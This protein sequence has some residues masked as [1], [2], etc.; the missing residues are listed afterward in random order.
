MSWGAQ[1]RSKDA[2][3]PSVAGGRSRKPKLALCGIQPH[4]K[5]VRKKIGGLLLAPSSPPPARTPAHTR[6]PSRRRERWWHLALPILPMCSPALP[7]PRSGLSSLP[8]SEP[9]DTLL[10][11][12]L[13]FTQTDNRSPSKL[14]TGLLLPS[15]D[16]PGR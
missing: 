6:A 10:S 12:P 5:V 8:N 14:Q 3:T 7:A 16:A 15:E 9:P 13:S 11:S 1:N 2:K 4:L